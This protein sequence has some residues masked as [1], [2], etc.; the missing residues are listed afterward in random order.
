MSFFGS[1]A[2]RIERRLEMGLRLIMLVGG[3][4]AY[5]GDDQ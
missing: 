3:V 2:S 1:K 5:Q 4:K